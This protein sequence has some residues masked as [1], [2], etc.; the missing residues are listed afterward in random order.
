MWIGTENFMGNGSSSAG[1]GKSLLSPTKRPLVRNAFAVMSGTAAGQVVV[2]L[3]SPLIT[4]IYTPE[5]FGLQGMFLSLV[6][7]LSPAIALRYPMAIVVARND[8]DAQRL[9]FLSLLIAF[10]LSVLLSFLLLV[11]QGP[12]LL[13]L[14]A[15][16]LGSLIWFLPLALFCVALRDV[17]DYRAA[18][19]GSFRLI[20]VVT[21]LQALLA[22]LARVLGGLIAPVA[23]VLIAISSIAPSV[24]AG[25]LAF[26]NRHQRQRLMPLRRPR[27]LALLRRHRDFPF[28]RVPTDVLNSA[29]QSVPVILLAA[30][31][32]PAAAGLYTLTRSVLNLPLNVIGVAIGNVLYARFAELEHARQP[33]M[34]LLIRATLALAAL[35]P[36]IVGAA[37]FAPQVFALVFGEEWREA[38]HYARWM[39]LWLGVSIANV[40]AVR[41][42]PV[43]RRQALMLVA[44]VI[45]LIVRILAIVAAFWIGGDAAAA[46]AAFSVVSL[47]FNAGLVGA[48][49]LGAQFHDAA[50]VQSSLQGLSK[51]QPS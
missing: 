28:Y 43:I 25:L 39:S 36:L 18:R 24:Q 6:T 8:T 22:N 49:M 16:P 26:G 27:A 29:S 41:L 13:V 30:L 31:F 9:A 7:I 3:F 35:A 4:R 47:I 20:G 33:L 51:V 37:W 34:P 2:V 19:I 14:G 21:F 42:A 40:P 48:L 15:E 23:A 50:K 1:L 46:V 17:A 45:F 10:A 44:N 38:G 12:M 5:V 32:S 11:A